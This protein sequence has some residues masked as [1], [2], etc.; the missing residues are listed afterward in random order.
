M[1]GEKHYCQMNV[2][3]FALAAAGVMGII[4]LLCT[5]FVAVAPDLA[6]KL[7]GTLVHLVNLDKAADVRLTFGGFLAGLIQ[8]VLY[9]YIGAWLLAFLHNK[10]CKQS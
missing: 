4:Y 7:F 10:F 5:V 1:N 9:T 6:L 3:G 2:N 8:A